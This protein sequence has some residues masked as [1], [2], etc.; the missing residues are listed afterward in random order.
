MNVEYTSEGI[1]LPQID[2]WLDNTSGSET[3]WMSHGHADHARGQHRFA[4]ATPQTAQVF[5]HRWGGYSDPHFRILDLGE[6][7]EFRGARLTAYPASHIVGAAQLL[8]EYGGERL[9]Y[10][11]DIKLRQPLC[12]M[13]T[14]IVPCDHLIIESTF[15]LPVYRFLNRDQARERIVNFAQECLADGDTPVFIGY[16]LGRGQE[17]VHTLCQAGVP[18]AVHGAI[19]ALLPVYERVGYEF[20][21]WQPYRARAVEGKALVVVPSFPSFRSVL[22]AKGTRYRLAYVSGWAMLDNA[23]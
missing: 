3:T 7:M 9:V 12:G 13:T 10:T 1:Y 6:S 20:A 14:E 4:I 5:H 21:G 23:R 16:A 11:G 8:V 22:E 2:L 17:I 19:A 18:T 15:G